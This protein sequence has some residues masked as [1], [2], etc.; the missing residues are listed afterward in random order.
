MAHEPH[1][2]VNLTNDA[3][4]GDTVEPHIHL[5]LAVF[6]AVEHRRF[7]ARA[8][9]TGVSAFV[10]PVGRIVSKTPTFARANL[11]GVVT[12]MEGRTIYAYAGDWVGLLCL[13]VLMW[14]TRMEIIGSFTRMWARV[15]RWRAPD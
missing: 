7:L 12:P 2:L 11:V 4:F 9:N 10:D 5:A 15:R 1:V 14:W 3:W 8:T 13:F 6:R